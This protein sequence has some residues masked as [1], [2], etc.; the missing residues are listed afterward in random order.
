MFANAAAKDHC[1]GSFQSCQVGA[2]IFACSITEHVYG[3]P[4]AGIIFI[5]RNQLAH[6]ARDSRDPKQAGTGV[7]QAF[8]FID[9]LLPR[10]VGDQ[11]RIQ[12]AGAS[13]HDQTFSGVKPI[14][15]SIEVPL[16][17]AQAEQPLP[18]CKVTILI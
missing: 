6:V 9:S 8:D 12:I 11:C 7:Q 16:R 13:S 17:I 3:Q 2:E 10:Q 5:G 4:S 1:I 15:V 18:R 14:E